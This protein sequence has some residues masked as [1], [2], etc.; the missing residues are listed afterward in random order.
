M[1]IPR[2][3][4]LVFILAS[5]PLG[6]MPASAQTPGT[7]RDLVGALAAALPSVEPQ[8]AAPLAPSG[9]WLIDFAENMCSLQ[10]PFG[11]GDA[12]VVFAVR[13]LPLIGQAELYF[14]NRA[15]NIKRP[16]PPRDPGAFRLNTP[17]SADEPGNNHNGRLRFVLS[18]SGDRT[19]AYFV[20][21]V[22]IDTRQRFVTF[23]LPREKVALLAASNGASFEL[24]E[25]EAV[26]IDVTGIGKALQVL[27]TCE[28]DLVTSWGIDKAARE[29]V[30]TPAQAIDPVNWITD[31]DYLPEAARAGIYGSTTMIWKVG[32]DGRTSE[33]RVVRSS[34]YQPLDQSAC[35][36]I[37][38]RARYKPALDA[39]GKPIVS[40]SG[41]TIR[42]MLPQRRR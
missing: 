34:R 12:E 2:V 18:P 41:R 20:A 5:L 13:T 29:A 37:L 33:C 25:E 24:D 27:S 7:I 21:T 28:E 22:K 26:T 35:R 11:T 3:P 30:R 6:A 4:A 17:G 40:W 32:T 8:A 9:K 23:D 38:A 36:A 19:E 1:R 16:P 15:R 42:W 39:Q 14:V 10:R 31:K